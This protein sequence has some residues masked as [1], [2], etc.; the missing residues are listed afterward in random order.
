MNGFSPVRSSP[1][2][3]PEHQRSL[4]PSPVSQFVTPYASVLQQMSEEGVHRLFSAPLASE[5]IRLSAKARNHGM[6]SLD[7]AADVIGTWKQMAVS[8]GSTGDNS[9]K[10]VLSLFDK[11]GQWSDPWVE[12]GYQVYRFDIQDNP[13]LGDVTKFDVEFFMEYFGDFEGAEVYAIIAACPCTDFA[14][15]GA[16]HFAAKDLDGRTAA[17][18]ELVHQT[19]R[20][21]E[22]YRPP[23]WAIEN[24]VGRIEKLAGLPPWRLSFNPC[25]LG[26]PYTK[27]TLIW[28]R[29]NADLPVAPVYPTEGSK[30]HTQYGGSSLATKNARSVTPAGFAYAFFMANNAYQHPALEITGKYDRIDP[31]LLSL[32]IENGL[33]LQDLSNLL[34]DAYYDCDDDAVTKLLSDILGEKPI[35]VVES[36]GQ[37]ALLI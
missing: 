24:P 8:Q 4:T 13:E 29:F 30:M 28:G 32:A 35:S 6:L 36:T 15:S 17:S 22:Y 14:N 12:A 27:K 33:K 25:D 16:R 31:R 7:D 10:V 19:L 9:D 1:S 2:T 11:S 5:V 20:L 26:E 21:V 18:I 37:L 23:I 3:A 34:D